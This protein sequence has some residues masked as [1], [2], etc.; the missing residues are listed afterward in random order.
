MSLQA[1][2]ERRSVRA[3]DPTYEIPEET[4]QKIVEAVLN[5][6]TAMN[7][8]DHDLIVCMSREKLNILAD[9]VMKNGEQSMR[10]RFLQRQQ[11]SGVSNP[12]TYDAPCVIFLQR[13]ERAQGNMT[14]I[15]AGIFAMAIMIAAK[16]LGLESVCLGCVTLGITPEVEQAIGL[17]KGQVA[18][19]VAIGKGKANQ[20]VI[21]KD[22]N[23]KVSYV[24]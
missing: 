19:G 1:L 23:I 18:L 12:V 24:K 3:Y 17:K 22:I 6:P 4:L 2:L 10:D 8:Q 20:E 16:S 5:T 13:N 14:D 7:C 15:D 9:A 21:K 11:K